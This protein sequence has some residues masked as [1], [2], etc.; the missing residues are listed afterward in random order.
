M[1]ML[2]AINDSWNEIR[3]MLKKHTVF[4]RTNL[5]R[6]GEIS[7]HIFFVVSGALRLYY[8]DDD[9]R[10]IS[11]QFFFEEQLV[12]SF[13][14]FYLE[15]ESKFSIESIEDSEILSL[16]KETFQMLSDKYPDIKDLV[17]KFACNRFIDYTNIFLSYLKNSPEERY[18]ELLKS[19]PEIL[20]RVP[21]HYIASYL[22]ITPVS[23]SRIRKRIGN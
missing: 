22:G 17:T 19:K 6:Q 14:S 3:P 9:G 11:F 16:D 4:A 1:N 13:E 7:T 12:S 21:Q 20:K 10:D 8:I 23:L 15:T 5:L 18:I 2:S